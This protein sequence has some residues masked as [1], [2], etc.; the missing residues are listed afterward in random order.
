MSKGVPPQHVLPS[1]LTA[2]ELTLQQETWADHHVATVVLASVSVQCGMPD[3]ARE[4]VQ[5]IWDAIS[6]SG[7]AKCIALGELVLARA[8]LERGDG[9][10]DEG[11]SLARLLNR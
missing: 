4:M 8:E 5:A 7:D 3:R 6:R 11:E 2:Y 1:A 10:A 9:I